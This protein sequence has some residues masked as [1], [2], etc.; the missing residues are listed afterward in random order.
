[1]TNLAYVFP[2]QGSQAV[3][4]LADVESVS[5]ETFGEASSVLGYD[6]WSLIANGPE[7]QLNQT[8]YTQPEIGRAHV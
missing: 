7:D 5:K 3:G 8:E 4:M 6:L 2:G 1:M